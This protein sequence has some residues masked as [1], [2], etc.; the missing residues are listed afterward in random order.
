MSSQRIFER[1]TR[2]NKPKDR[3][4]KTYIDNLIPVLQ[5]LVRFVW[6]VERYPAER[7][8]IR[9][10]NVD[11]LYGTTQLR[12]KS[13]SGALVF[14]LAADGVVKDEDSGCAGSVHI[15]SFQPFHMHC[16]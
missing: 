1:D 8:G 13:G 10:V 11:T 4:K 7:C 16:F 12:G 5:Q 15:V 9:L 2:I 3:Q 6:Q 14:G